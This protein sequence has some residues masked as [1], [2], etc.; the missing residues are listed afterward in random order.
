M[1]NINKKR[2]QPLFSVLIANYNNGKYLQETLD[3]IYNQTYTNWEIIIVDDC[4]TDHSVQ[5]YKTLASNDR[6]RIFYNEENQGCGYTKRRCV[7]EAFGDIGGFV[8]RDDTILPHA[9]EKMVELHI[10]KP[11]YS[12]I[13]SKSYFCDENMNITGEYTAARQVNS[14]DPIFFNLNGAITHFATFK[15][16][17][18]NKTEGIDA[19]L[20][21]AVD[22]DLYLKLYEVGKIFFIDEA[23]YNYRIHSG[24]ISTSSNARKAYYWAWV[25]VFAAA[26]RRGINLESSFFD[27]FTPKLEYEYIAAKYNKYK[28]IDK[29]IEKIKSLFS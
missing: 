28:K 3:S 1:S 9:L 2:D 18:Y 26:R 27:Y 17:F 12:R 22:Q 29:A 6:I 24:G 23:L 19:Y 16:E 20:E 14:E 10:K 21:R 5:I 13:H 15:K 11:E 4:S 25:V 7:D 8:D